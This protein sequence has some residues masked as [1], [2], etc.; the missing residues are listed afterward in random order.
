MC[1]AADATR[2]YSLRT[3]ALGRS[4]TTRTVEE[5][6]MRR[7]TILAAAVC[8]ALLLSARAQASSYTINTNAMTYAFDGA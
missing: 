8:G 4:A 3:W 7:G 5:D 6:F 2:H 1:A